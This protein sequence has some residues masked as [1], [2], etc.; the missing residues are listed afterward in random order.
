MFPSVPQRHKARVRCPMRYA[1]PQ[2]IAANSDES[3]A[4]LVGETQA[5]R[6]A[7]MPRP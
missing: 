1:E 7:Q 2:Q 3:F 6:R 4:E 5:H